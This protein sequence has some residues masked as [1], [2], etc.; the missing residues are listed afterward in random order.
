MKEVGLCLRLVKAFSLLAVLS[1]GLLA[2]NGA[3]AD[4]AHPIVNTRCST[5]G[6]T[7]LSDNSTAVLACVHKS[8]TDSTLVWRGGQPELPRPAS[9]ADTSGFKTSKPRH[10]DIGGDWG[11]RANECPASA[12]DRM[13][14]TPVSF[15]PAG[16]T[17]IGTD[18]CYASQTS[19]LAT[20]AFYQSLVA[21]GTDVSECDNDHHDECC[22]YV[23]GHTNVCVVNGVFFPCSTP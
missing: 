15:C 18:G 22:F 19:N 4:D 23:C 12:P 8:T 14:N 21:R 20:N 10:C 13:N 16:S 9:I 6:K 2:S 3:F 11:W 17:P 1:V 7:A 5:I